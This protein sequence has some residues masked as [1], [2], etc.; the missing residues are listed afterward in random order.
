MVILTALALSVVLSCEN[1]YPED[2]ETPVPELADNT[3]VVGKELR[4]F[5]SVAVSNIGEYLCIAASTTEGVGSFDAMFEQEEYFYVAVSP[6]LNGKE[7]D[8]MTEESLYTVISTLEGAVIETLAPTMLE[9]I[10]EGKCCFEYSEGVAEVSVSLTL[11]SGVT[12]SAKL[13]AE[14]AGIVVNE[15]IFAID[16]DEKPVR[17][18]F[19]LRKDGVT[20]LY[21][22]PAGIDYFDELGITTYY[23]YII[24]DDGQCHGRTLSAADVISVGYAD[25]F[26]EMIVDANDTRVTGSLNVA[27][28]PDDPAHYIVSADLDF[29]GTSLKLRFDGNTIDANAREEVKNEVIYEGKSY[30]ITSA[31]LDNMPSAEGTCTVM[32]VTELGDILHI[33][34]PVG[35]I[36]GNAHGFSQSPYLY[37]KYAGKTFSKTE[38]YSG[39]VTI[40]V[41]DGMMKVEATNYDDLEAKYEG[42]YEVV[43]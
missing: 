33:T 35:F 41:E 32:L 22:T 27:D 18:A 8:L 37:M 2:P 43:S 4:N 20:S 28:D 11:V 3:C 7:F 40:S 19:S 42:G 12:F 14:E 29:A 31:V 16:G 38:G 10:G 23:A 30:A 25:N 15:N 21:L 17:T 34:L 6:L 39:T 1:P 24:L 26:N 5:V 36:D 13:S 9:E